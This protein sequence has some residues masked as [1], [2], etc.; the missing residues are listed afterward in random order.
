V[1]VNYGP[2][3]RDIRLYEGQAYFKVAHD[4]SRPFVVT[5]GDTRVT[6][7]GTEFD[8]RLAPGRL[9][10]TLVTGRVRVD[11]AD[12]ENTDAHPLAV[13]DPGEQYRARLNTPH[14]VAAVDI[15]RTTAWRRGQLI[16]EGENLGDAVAE[17]NRYGR[18]RIVVRDDLADLPIAGAFETGQSD[19]FVE[20]LT[21]YF[22]IRVVSQNDAEVVLAW[23]EPAPDQR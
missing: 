15:V 14:T 17:M 12:A 2:G 10:V 4:A 21:A 9:A 3:R 16:F 13:L 5:A 7:L 22:P 11:R 8:V 6:A 20:A 1:S 18:R 19:T 23:R